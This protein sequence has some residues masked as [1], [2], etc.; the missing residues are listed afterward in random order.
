MMQPDFPNHL[1]RVVIIGAGF[2][3]LK[4]ARSLANSPVR[5]TLVDRNNYHLFQPLL[6]QVATAGLSPE[7]IAYPVR[8][9]LRR[10]RNVEFRMAHVENVDLDRRLLTTS[11]GEI[12]Y[13]YLILAAGGQ[14]HTF[15]LESVKQNAFGLKNIKD[16]TAIRNHILTLFEQAGQQ[17]DPDQRRAMLTFVIAGGGPTG[18][19][20]A[21]AISELVR[22][23]LAQD[24]PALRG[25]EVNVILLEAANRL[26]AHLP[27]EL[28]QATL[29]ALQTKQVKVRFGSAVAD[30]TGE[31]VR[32][33]GGE[34][35]ETHT[36][37]WAAGAR[38]AGLID[39]LGLPQASLGR[40]K[41]QPTLQ[42]PGR[43]EVFVIGD[44]AEF[45]GPDGKPLPMVAPV[46]MQQAAQAGAN[47]RHLLKGEQPAVFIFHDP[48]MM[49]TIG[50][51]Q[52]V[53]WL[54]RIRL[55]GFIAWG[56]WL[57]VHIM[58]LI[59]FRNRLVVLLNWAWEYIFY[60]RAIRLIG[61]EERTGW[62]APTALP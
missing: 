42:V 55:K 43:P 36:L 30:Y 50:R 24:Y 56:A 17:P 13:D 1:P 26:L 53:A 27:D 23:L 2:G 40:I 11:S 12:P 60:D 47:I 9:I 48:G 32:L 52:A 46:A 57:V 25:A 34:E 62:N 35:I 28:S 54:G 59:G 49:A 22:M 21:G 41:V 16:A 6:Y 58:Q 44:A 45:A 37:I 29:R 51:N 8:A 61:M 20:T 33:R 19:E 3:G 18:V 39:R 31:V 38:A 15:G 5:V 4:A 14:T 10:Q 7:E